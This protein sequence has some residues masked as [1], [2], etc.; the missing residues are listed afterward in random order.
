MNIERS[1]FARVE[2][3][4]GSQKPQLLEGAQVLGRARVWKWRRFWEGTSFE[5]GAL[6][7]GHEFTRAAN[8]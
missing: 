8:T 7:E 6:R 5:K 1:T 3:G 4:V 2:K